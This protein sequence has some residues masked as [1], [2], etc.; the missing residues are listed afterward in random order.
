MTYQWFVNEEP[1]LDSAGPQLTLQGVGRALNNATVRCRAEND[2]G[3][4]SDSR[5]IAVLCKY[6]DLSPDMISCLADRSL[7]SHE[8]NIPFFTENRK[9]EVFTPSSR[10]PLMLT[11]ARRTDSEVASATDWRPSLP[12]MRPGKFCSGA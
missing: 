3:A 11:V 5:R 8:K 10:S 4:A 2:V 1:Q 6:A 12:L 7:L 9:S